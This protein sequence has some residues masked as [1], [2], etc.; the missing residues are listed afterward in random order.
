[1]PC[2]PQ[3]GFAPAR[4]SPLA[5][6]AMREG[7]F[8][9]DRPFAAP[10]PAAEASEP[11]RTKRP[12]ACG[13]SLRGSGRRIFTRGRRAIFVGFCTPAS[14][15]R[16]K[17]REPSRRT[18]PPAESSSYSA[19]SSPTARPNIRRGSGFMKA[20]HPAAVEPGNAVAGGV[21]GGYVRRYAGRLR[22]AADYSSVSLSSSVMS[23]P[24]R[25]KE[26]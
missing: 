13:Y 6:R 5:G 10:Q 20:L 4:G 9:Q 15:S 23:T 11:A 18:S 26:P 19:G 24:E 8:V 7:L 17:G 2:R 1:M 3:K 14:K 22:R 12:S 25:A 21:G 16:H